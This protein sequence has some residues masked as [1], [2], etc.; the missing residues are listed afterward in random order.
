MFNDLVGLEF[1]WGHRPDDGSGKTD[2]FHLVC[3][4]RRRLG[5]TDY[6]EQ[7]A[8][9]YQHFSEA[10]LP[11]SEVA[12]LVLGVGGRRVKEGPSPGLLALIPGTIGGALGVCTDHGLLMIGPGGSVIHTPHIVPPYLFDLP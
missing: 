3:E 11:R 6:E 12:R 7:F 9:V 8:S 4:A 10:T 2:C 5:Q 1:G